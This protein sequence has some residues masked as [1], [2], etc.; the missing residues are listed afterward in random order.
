VLLS[1]AGRSDDAERCQQLRISRRL[2]KPVKPST[3]LDA[4]TDT[5]GFDDK[6]AAHM[7]GSDSLSVH[8]AETTPLR[9]LLAEDGLVN[10][11]VATKLLERCGHQVVVVNNGLEAL[12][13]TERDRFDVILMDV[14]MPVMD[15]FTATSEIR[16][17]EASGQQRTPIIAMTAHAMKGDR[18]QCLEAGMDGYISKPIRPDEL[19]NTIE[20]VVV[21]LHD[22][23]PE[24]SRPAAG[25]TAEPATGPLDPQLAMEQMGGDPQIAREL[26]H[27]FRDE[28]PALLDAIRQAVRKA[29][30]DALQRAAHTLK[31]SISVFAAEPARVA[32]LELEQIGKNNALE[33]AADAVAKL[34]TEIDRLLPALTELAES[35]RA[36]ELE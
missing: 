19:Y 5:L 12:E 25:T 3:L 23:S 34:Q 1:S 22:Q 9:I 11:Q 21:Q 27:V 18:E 32:A 26:I 4:I 24:M 7:A 28:C 33:Q 31:G 35:T 36:P 8:A 10:Q 20:S 14:Q 16:Q 17:R 2:I 30:A 29:D 6:S 15:G 13:R